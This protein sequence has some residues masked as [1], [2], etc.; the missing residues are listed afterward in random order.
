MSGDILKK[1]REELG[2]EI[3][4]I[5]ELLKIKAD[6][7]KWIEGDTFEKLP[8]AVYTMGYIR[9]YAKH[10]GV[11]SDPI[12]QYYTTHLSQPKPATLVPVGFSKKKTPLPVYLVIAAAV[13]AA[14]YFFGPFQLQ[15]K[16]QGIT[17]P[18]EMQPAEMP[19]V[20]VAVSPDIT[21]SANIP[22]G[23]SAPSK[24]AATHVAP[25]AAPMGHSVDISAVEKTWLM[26]RMANGKTEELMLQP[27]GTKNWSFQGQASLKVGNA[28]GI[29]LRV[30]GKD[31]G[32]PGGKGQVVTVSLPNS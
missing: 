1:R 32:S 18:M 17:K 20:P 30:D 6:Y 11:D 8:A 24:P 29:R 19:A 9:S 28:G 4:Q 27:G 15:H 25:A 21:A 5:S 13:I 16:Q 10:L 14:V 26:I 23:P 12:I 22:A 7:L 31:I 3:N 2:L